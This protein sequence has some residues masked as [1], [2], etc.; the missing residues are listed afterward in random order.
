MSRY[1]CLTGNAKRCF[2][3]RYPCLETSEIFR[4]PVGSTELQ[5]EGRLRAPRNPDQF[6]SRVL[7]RNRPIRSEVPSRCLPE[8][9]LRHGGGSGHT[10]NR[11]NLPF[12][13]AE[14]FSC[15]DGTSRDFVDAHIGTAEATKTPKVKNLCDKAHLYERGH[16][17]KIVSIWV[18]SA[19]LY[20][21]NCQRM[22]R[23]FLVSA[24]PP[25]CIR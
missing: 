14:G 15:F 25:A 22:S 1:Y 8:G 9:C 17:K 20:V 6:E 13:L 16:E 24:K 2:T 23:S 21:T 10:P 19:V 18:A 3:S 7:L 11:R 12:Y 4:K 5:V